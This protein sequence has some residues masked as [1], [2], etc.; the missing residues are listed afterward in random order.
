MTNTNFKNS[1]FKNLKFK[2]FENNSKILKI[3][4]F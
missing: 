4:K 1:K 2:K 3:L